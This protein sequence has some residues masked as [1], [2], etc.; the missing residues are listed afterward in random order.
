M[1]RSLFGAKESKPAPVKLMDL[2][3][4]ARVDAVITFYEDCSREKFDANEKRY[5]GLLNSPEISEP[6]FEAVV[7][8]HDRR[9]VELGL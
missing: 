8:A 5:K 9:K 3:T 2:D 4:D 1:S 6:Q 7:E